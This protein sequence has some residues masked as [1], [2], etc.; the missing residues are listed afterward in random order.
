MRQFFLTVSLAAYIILTSGCA[1]NFYL[2][3]PVESNG[4]IEVIQASQNSRNASQEEVFAVAEDL[5]KIR[6]PVLEGD[7]AVNEHDNS[8]I[9][10]DE[11]LEH[12]EAAHNLREKGN[13]DEALK[14]LDQAYLLIMDVNTDL[15]PGLMQQKEDL[16]FMISK[17]ILEIY[18]ARGSVVTGK[19]KAIPITLN[20]YTQREIDSFTIGREKQSFREA[21]KRSGK[22]RQHIVEE[23]KMAGLPTELSWLPLIE[24]GFKT[25]ALSKARALGLWQFIP[26]TGYKF[27]LKR[28]TYIDERLD[29]EKSARAAVAYLKELHQLF[30]DWATVLAA[31]NCGEGRVLRIIRG[32]NVNYLDN[33]W[34]LYE[35]LPR[36]T[37]RYV[38]RFLACLHIINHPEQYG[39]ENVAVDPPSQYETI[40]V[41]KQIHLTDAAHAIG[42]T[43]QVLADLNPELRY[44]VLPEKEYV[45]RVPMN[46]SSL[47]MA[48]MDGIPVSGM[49]RTQYV[50]HRV[51]SGET[52]STIARSY[53]TNV[54]RI[55]HENKIQR[56]GYVVAGSILRIPQNG[57]LQVQRTAGTQEETVHA[58]ME[59]HLYR[60]KQGDSLWEI[61]RKFGTTVQVI[62][63]ANDLSH[64]RLQIGQ[65]LKVPKQ[66]QRQLVDVHSDSP[67]IGKGGKT[68]L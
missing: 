36:E 39:L 25:R 23:L 65:V 59:R 9:L 2:A 19:Y 1:Q 7:P 46:S 40:L 22:Y 18:A 21:Y 53:R 61:A 32:Q 52:L 13:L 38:P 30:G 57:N 66:N 6:E 31:Y 42:S 55:A 29:P 33:F 50:Y 3:K 16:R 20:Q 27:G 58:D 8:Q 11:A 67:Q 26:S 62:R 56:H 5:S 41:Q 68:V 14:E 49:I 10:I 15:F 24:S 44:R 4:G 63:Q 35:K 51:K 47:L 17:R 64:N 45:L 60:V 12:C 54:K 48:K 28:D 43:E 37:A 34:D